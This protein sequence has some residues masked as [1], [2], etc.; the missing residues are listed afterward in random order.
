[1]SL[2]SD[3]MGEAQRSIQ[4]LTDVVRDVLA[5]NQE[6]CRHLERS[7]VTIELKHRSAP[8]ALE[9]IEC[10]DDDVSTIRPDRDTC[11]SESTT[12]VNPSPEYSF[13]FEQDLR[14]SRVYT[15]VSRRIG[16]RSDPDPMS[17]PSSA[18]CSIGSSFLSGLSLADVSNISLISLPIPPCSL[19]NGQ[20]Y[21]KSLVTDPLS[22]Y[23]PHM[24]HPAPR[25]S[26]KILLFGVYTPL[27]I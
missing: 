5:Q 21:I 10:T 12:L 20:R 8:S 6:I 14:R 4:S 13:S 22:D 26:G 3:G 1:M 27:S 19:S 23:L 7:D 25:S 17:L 9:S 15:R 18:G 11:Y 16:R 2:H 24:F